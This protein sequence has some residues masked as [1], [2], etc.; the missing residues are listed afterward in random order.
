MNNHDHNQFWD[1]Y[2]QQARQPIERACRHQSRIKTDSSMDIDD[3]IA[4]IDTRVWTMLEKSAYPT[5]HDDP[6][7]EEAIDRLIRHAP[8]LARWAYLALCRSHFTDLSVV[9]AI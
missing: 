7:P 5:F 2:E 8:T 6:T 4:W 9:T 1:L 3:M